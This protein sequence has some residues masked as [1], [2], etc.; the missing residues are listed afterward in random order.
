MPIFS[1]SSSSSS[2]PHASWKKVPRSARDVATRLRAFSFSVSETTCSHGNDA[3]RVVRPRN[4][5]M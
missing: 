1:K 3:S 5:R 2:S 4:S